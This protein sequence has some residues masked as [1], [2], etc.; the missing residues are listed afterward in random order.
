[1]STGAA[2]VRA[3]TATTP[4]VALDLETD[5]VAAFRL[6]EGLIDLM[7]GFSLG[8][9]MASEVP[10]R[11]HPISPFLAT[12]SRLASVNGEADWLRSHRVAPTSV[13]PLRRSV[14]AEHRGSERNAST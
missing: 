14:D 11:R 13:S 2:N 10:G 7:S 5:P 8:S 9:F 1:V 12:G 6:S 4:I 3:A